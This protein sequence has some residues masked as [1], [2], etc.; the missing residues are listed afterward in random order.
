MTYGQGL[1]G[2]AVLER[3]AGTSAPTGSSP[4]SQLPTV[5]VAGVQGH[6]LSTPLGTVVTFTKGCGQL[7]RGRLGHPD[8]GGDRSG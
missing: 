4:L 6:E 1:G 2:I 5:T 3:P 8:R 7:R